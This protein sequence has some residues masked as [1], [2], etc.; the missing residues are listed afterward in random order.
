MCPK[1][2]SPE[3]RREMAEEWREKHFQICRPEAVERKN[4]KPDALER[5]SP[6]PDDLL[7]DTKDAWV[8]V[9]KRRVTSN[10]EKKGVKPDV[11]RPYYKKNPETQL[12]CVQES[13][14]EERPKDDCQQTQAEIRKDE[15]TKE[16]DE[17]S[18]AST[19]ADDPKLVSFLKRVGPQFDPD[20]ISTHS[21]AG[22]YKAL[23]TFIH[24]KADLKPLVD[25]GMKPLH[26]NMLFAAIRKEPGWKADANS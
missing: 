19:T 20:F 9:D 5:K 13:P 2:L 4:P 23:I 12:M 8:L 25:A 26:V 14:D 15:D 7:S 18:N 6:K 11:L 1:K 24:E 3:K 10:D 16:E 22:S 17:Q 21:G